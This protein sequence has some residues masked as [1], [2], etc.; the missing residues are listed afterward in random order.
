MNGIHRP[1]IHLTLIPD[2]RSI[3]Q[4]HCITAPVYLNVQYIPPYRN[5]CRDQYAHWYRGVLTHVPHILRTCC[6]PGRELVPDLV[7]RGWMSGSF[8]R[9]YRDLARYR[10]DL[11]NDSSIDTRY[12]RSGAT[13]SIV[14]HLMLYNY[15]C[16]PFHFHDSS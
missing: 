5:I 12:F 10:S 9:A 4:L 8:L 6:P 1:S 2:C 15:R 11:D 14:P 13:P 7:S 3:F 16:A